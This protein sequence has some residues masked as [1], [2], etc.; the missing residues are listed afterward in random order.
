MYNAKPA[1]IEVI[2]T[3]LIPSLLRN[4]GPTKQLILLDDASPLKT[5][6]RAL[7]DKYRPDLEKSLG[8]FRYVENDRN[9]GFSGSYNKGMH[10]A[11]GNAI[12]IANSDVYF[13]L[14]SIDAM[15]D[16]LRAH[17]ETGA[18]GPVTNYA[19]SFQ[20]TTLFRRLKDHSPE[21][22]QRIEGFAS[23]LRTVMNG[24]TFVVQEGLVGFCLAFGKDTLAE[25]GY[26][27]ERYKY[28]M[29]EDADINRRIMNSGRKVVLDAAT[30]VE[31]GG[32]DGGSISIDLR[33]AKAMK[34]AFVNSLRYAMKW[35]DI[36]AITI[37]MVRQT[38]QA[39]G[40]GTVTN[41]ILE[42]AEKAGVKF[43]L[44]T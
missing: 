31:H 43:D 18:V 13:P 14:D 8:E 36:S 5:Q 1:T 41:D 33:S 32:S 2:D 28:G 26:F 39:R 25:I 37:G 19:Y 21:E 16:V 22:M 7:V 10:M 24:R 44:K 27:D 29:Y 9:L 35:H 20:N 11:D 15:V 34:A 42:A 3:L 40:I 30:F 38:L 6:T 17:H 12:M 4:A 23:K